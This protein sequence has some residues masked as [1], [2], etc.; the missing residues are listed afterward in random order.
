MNRLPLEKRVLLLSGL[1]EGMSMRALSRQIGVGRN[2][3]P[4]LLEAAANACDVFHHSHVLEVKS[5][6][7]ECDEVW[8]FCLYEGAPAQP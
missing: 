8:S 6:A 7:L 5:R 1:V 2:T 4:R 3:V